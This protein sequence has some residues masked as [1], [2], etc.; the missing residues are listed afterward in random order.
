MGQVLSLMY[1]NKHMTTQFGSLFQLAK[2]EKPR[3]E[4]YDSKLAKKE[5]LTMLLRQH[6]SVK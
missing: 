4:K 5:R 1:N 3:A 6:S 2:R